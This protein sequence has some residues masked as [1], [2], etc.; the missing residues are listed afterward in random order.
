MESISNYRS[1]FKNKPEYCE[2]ILGSSRF[3]GQQIG[4][5]YAEA[6]QVVKQIEY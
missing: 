4:V 1:V 5:K 3:R 6:F 2:A